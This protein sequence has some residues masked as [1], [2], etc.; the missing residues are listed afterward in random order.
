M[1]YRDVLYGPWELPEVIEKLMRT[2]QMA[3]LRNITQSTLPNGLI[4]EGPMPSRFHHGLGVCYLASLV[5]RHNQALSDYKGLLLVAA[6]LHD[7]GNPPFSHLSEHFLKEA[8]GKNGESFLEVMLDGS[9][10]EKVLK[11]FGMRTEE[12]VAMVTGSEKP[13]S[14]VLH[15]SMD[16]DN[17]DNVGRHNRFA[18]LTD[19]T[20]DA[21]K[22]ASSFFFNGAMWHLPESCFSDARVWQELRFRVYRHIYR[23]PHLNLAMMVYRALEIAFCEEEIEN[24]FFFHDDNTALS[25]LRACNEKTARLVQSATRWAWYDEVV[26]AEFQNP[27]EK[28]RTLSAHWKGRKRLADTIAE[29]L[30]VSQEK[31]CAYIGAGKEKRRIHMPFITKNARAFYD[32]SDETPIY[33][34]KVYVPNDLSEKK[35]AIHDIVLSE[36]S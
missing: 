20:Y 7:A 22:I 21:Q 9:E 19:A 10:T 32:N 3:R 26:S 17:L 14:E 11:D 30:G 31:V 15:G 25:Y 1:Q 2:K 5:V 18:H 33:R 28:L 16:L 13:L 8:T 36:I 27:S 29:K 12:V 35:N 23:S 6:L 24:D 4:V 34:V